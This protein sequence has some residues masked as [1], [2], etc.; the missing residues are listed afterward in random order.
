[1]ETS[2]LWQRRIS[3]VWIARIN[4]KPWEEKWSVL[5][6]NPGMSRLPEAMHISLKDDEIAYL[7][8]HSGTIALAKTLGR[9]FYL[10]TSDEEIVLF[11]EP[12]D[13]IVASAFDVGEKIK[14]GL[15]CT[16]Y[17]IRELESPLIVLP[18]GHPAS[19]RLKTVVSI[20]PKIRI[21]CK[22]QPGTH[23]EQDLLCGLEEF[24]GLEVLSSPN[25]AIVNNFSGKVAV[26][27]FYRSSG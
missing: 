19:K 4:S 5:R 10:D 25:G 1:L 22:I 11:T 23:P 9:F 14:S 18:K 6:A 27:T 3:N 21:S 26:D 8:G 16:L 13:L 2:N 24:Q 17:Q 7:L 20:G 15:K 12:D